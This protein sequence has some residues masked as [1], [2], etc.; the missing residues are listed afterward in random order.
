MFKLNLRKL[1]EIKY[2]ELKNTN[3]EVLNKNKNILKGSYKRNNI[4]IYKLGVCLVDSPCKK[5]NTF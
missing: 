2:I 5:Y 3:K 4:F 1:L